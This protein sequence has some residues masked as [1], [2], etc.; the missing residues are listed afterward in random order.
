MLTSTKPYAASTV[1]MTMYNFMAIK[2]RP[3]N[4]EELL[5][6]CRSSQLPDTDIELAQV[7]AEGLVERGRV[8]SEGGMFWITD[9]RR[10]FV[11]HRDRSDA[12]EVDETGNSL[13]GWNGWKVG[14]PGG[15][16]IPI[17]E[18]TR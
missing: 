4:I 10:R 5:D 13:G 12:D 14:A 2:G 11:T 6:D 8:R 15:G 17:E 3:A 7:A 1:G 16:L 9:P 18:V